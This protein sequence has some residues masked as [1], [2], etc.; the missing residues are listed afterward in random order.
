MGCVRETVP[1]DVCVCQTAVGDCDNQA[2]GSLVS[3]GFAEFQVASLN[4]DSECTIISVA[5]VQL[6]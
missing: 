5:I 3:P 6:H 1:G 4:Y 2:C